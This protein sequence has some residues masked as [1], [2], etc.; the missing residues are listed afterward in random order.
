MRFAHLAAFRLLRFSIYLTFNEKTFLCAS[1]LSLRRPPPRSPLSGC[2][3]ELSAA[4]DAITQAISNVRTA[5]SFSFT[6]YRRGRGERDSLLSTRFSRARDGRAEN[7][8]KAD[9]K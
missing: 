8:E 9:G 6:F 7:K 1:G 5:A 3:I 2:V 4:L